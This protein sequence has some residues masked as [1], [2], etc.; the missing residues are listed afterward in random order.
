MKP[1]KTRQTGQL[2]DRRGLLKNKTW[3]YLSINI[4]FLTSK[5]QVKGMYV[6]NTKRHTN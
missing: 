4:I 3:M 1:W 2:S 5:K 6:E